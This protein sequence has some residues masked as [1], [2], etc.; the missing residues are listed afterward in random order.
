MFKLARFPHK[1]SRFFNALEERF[2]WDHFAYSR[3]LVL[4]A[5][6]AW[7]RR[8]VSNL[9]RYLE[10]TT[11]RSRFNHFLHQERWDPAACLRLKA[12]GMLAWLK[13]RRGERLYLLVDDSS[14]H[15]C[16]R[17]MDAVGWIYD[18]GSGRKVRGHL[19]VT[20]VLCSR[21][22][23][24]PLGIRLYV[25]EEHAKTLGIPLRK[26]T[27]LAADLIEALTPTA[28]ASK[29]SSRTSSSTWALANTR[30]APAEPQLHTCI[31][32]ASPT[33]S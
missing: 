33:P 22:H 30:T 21:G 23:T 16:G 27:E 17:H 4:A 11:H 26:L 24:I 2:L 13:P 3:Q 19:C 9:Y 18:H 20:A 29:S 32:Y 28:G 31:W 12:S 7:G 14:K 1:L 8:N 5:A 10:A 15:Q 6:F 25:K